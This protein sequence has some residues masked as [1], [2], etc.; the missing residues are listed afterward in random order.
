MVRV[1]VRRSLRVRVRVRV[2]V[3]AR[4]SYRVSQNEGLGLK[5]GSRLGLG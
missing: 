5:T 1:R 4:A 2:A 3:W